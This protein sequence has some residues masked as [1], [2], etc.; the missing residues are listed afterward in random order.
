MDCLRI[1]SWNINNRESILSQLVCEIDLALWLFG[2]APTEIYAVGNEEQHYIQVHLGFSKGGMALIDSAV[3]PSG[4]PYYS[5]SVIGSTGAAYADD[6]H[7]MQLLYQPNDPSAL[8]TTQGNSHQLTQIQAFVDAL[9]EDVEPPIT[10]NEA[11]LA[12]QITESAI[13]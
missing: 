5:L 7:N 3:L 10:G 6:H 13:E 1:H 8:K 9:I 4:S 12:L 2:K 11:Y